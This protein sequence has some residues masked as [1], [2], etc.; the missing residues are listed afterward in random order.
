MRSWTW[1]WLQKLHGTPWSAQS[2]SCQLWLVLHHGMYWVAPLCHVAFGLK[3]CPP[4]SAILPSPVWINYVCYPWVG[5]SACCPFDAVS[6][7]SER[8]LAPTLNSHESSKGKTSKTSTNNL[9][10]IELFGTT[11]HQVWPRNLSWLS[12]YIYLPHHYPVELERE[13]MEDSYNWGHAT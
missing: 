2:N 5:M 12:I 4:V 9:Q 6:E 1:L 13:P 8:I 3:T 7:Y 10:K 11:N